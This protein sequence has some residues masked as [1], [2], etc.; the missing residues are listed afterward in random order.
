[1]RRG[2]R[3]AVIGLALGLLSGFSGCSWP[4]A[5]RTSLKDA[6]SPE[7]AERVQA[8]G[9]RAQ[10]A[11]DAGDLELAEREL[12]QLVAL[13]PRSPEGYQRLGR[14]LMLVG[15]ADDAKVN[16]ERALTL[17]PDYVGALI[18]LG[19]IEA[20]RGD[21]ESAIKRFEAAVEIEPRDATAQLALGRELE[22]LGR[23]DK[24]LAAYFRALEND[25]FS[26]EASRRVASMQLARNDAD[27][28]LA[29][30]DQTVEMAP[31]DAEVLLLRGRAHLALRQVPQAVADLRAASLRLPERPDI[32]F[33]LALA[34]DA[35]SRP[36][37]AL[38]SAE[39]ALKLAPDFADARNLT[40]RLR[41]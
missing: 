35:A 28:A 33:F 10:A 32:H 22:A 12:R 16:F 23:T 21:A 17:D 24:A 3:I 27:Q 41:R 40:Q 34:L 7:R 31:G 38:K 20:A 37:D 13:S 1:M 19:E 5:R 36:D 18:G 30:L 29:R 11:V 15:R 26:I 8:I 25:P 6:L 14:V 9:E 4:G 39:Q 2:A